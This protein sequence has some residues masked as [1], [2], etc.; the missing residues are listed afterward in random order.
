MQVVLAELGDRLRPGLVQ[1]DVGGHQLGHGDIPSGEEVVAHRIFRAGQR[2]PSPSDEP[3]TRSRVARVSDYV[4][5][6]LPPEEIARQRG[7]YGPLAQS[8]RELADASIRT[9][10]DDDE[11]RAAQAEIEAITARLRERQLDGVVR[12]PVQRRRPGPGLGQRRGRPAQP[13]RPAA[14]DRARRRRPRRGRTS[15]SARRT[16]VP[17]AWSTAAS[18]R[19]SSTSCSARPPAPAASRA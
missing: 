8:V 12:R 2:T 10:V 3:G 13:G 17:R 9:E 5:E 11:I 19:W 4:H 15:T 18:R 7:L 1:A 16:R 14:G 6:D